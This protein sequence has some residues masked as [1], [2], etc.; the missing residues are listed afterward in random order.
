[1]LSRVE[2]TPET[3]VRDAMEQPLLVAHADD[4]VIDVVERMR[5]AGVDRCPVVDRATRRVVGFLSPSDILRVR[6][7]LSEE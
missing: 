5:I 2:A 1:V 4:E 3:H 6:M 7:R